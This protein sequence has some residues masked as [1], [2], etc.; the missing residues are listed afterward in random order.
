MLFV[1]YKMTDSAGAFIKKNTMSDYNYL[2]GGT[3]T[4]AMTYT[5]IYG[6]VEAG[7]HSRRNDSSTQLIAWYRFQGS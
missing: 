5:R 4:K 7:A 3:A 2:N 1:R 6:D